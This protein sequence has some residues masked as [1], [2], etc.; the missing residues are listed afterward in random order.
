LVQEVDA[1]SRPAI[2]AGSGASDAERKQHDESGGAEVQSVASVSVATTSNSQ[3]AL[4]QPQTDTALEE[5][6]ALSLV[7][8]PAG[9]TA[10]D[11]PG[12]GPREDTLAS[13][14]ERWRYDDQVDAALEQHD[15]SVWWH[16]LI[17]MLSGHAQLSL[18][19][20]ARGEQPRHEPN[21]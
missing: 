6:R 20:E 16:N 8:E 21:E 5:Q 18:E 13:E 2:E 3:V 19:E 15:G 7:P 17:P 14:E 4:S 11:Q 12:G 1:E 10:Q 9:L